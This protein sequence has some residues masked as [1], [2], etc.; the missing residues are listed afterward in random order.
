MIFSIVSLLIVF[1]LYYKSVRTIKKYTS[2]TWEIKKGIICYSCKEK[3][4]DDEA[5]WMYNLDMNKEDFKLCLACD[6]DQKLD[7]FVPV[8]S[9]SQKNSNKFKKYLISKKGDKIL[10]FYI[11]SFVLFFLI[12]LSLYLI[13]FKNSNLFSISTSIIN[14]IY[15]LFFY[16][17]VKITSGPE[18]ST[19]K[20]ED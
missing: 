12:Q 16:Y 20:E 5:D 10:Y 3:V 13:G 1:S 7:Q 9:L 4:S 17:K 11:S 2:L 8:R 18:K 14:I 15:A 19:F 6:R